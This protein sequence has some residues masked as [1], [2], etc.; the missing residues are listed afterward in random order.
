MASQEPQ[1]DDL[2][3]NETSRRRLHLREVRTDLAGYDGIGVEMRAAR[4]RAGTEL[5]DIAQKLRISQPYLEAIEEGR[6]DELPGHVYVFGFLKTYA[7][8]LELDEGI[9]IERFRAETSGPQRE[10]TRLAF[11]SAMDRG[12]LPTGRLLLGGLLVAVLAYAGW[13]VFTSDQRSTA[14]RVAEIP[15]RLAVPATNEV[16]AT[17]QPSPVATSEV[18]PNQG[19]DAVVEAPPPTVVERAPVGQDA[20]IPTDSTPGQ[21]AVLVP[22]EAPV[23]SA[24]IPPIAD[25]A[26]SADVVT[27]PSQVVEAA[28]TTADAESSVVVETPSQEA[29]QP[30]SVESPATPVVAQTP[31]AGTSGAIPEPAS[32]TNAPVDPQ[33]TPEPPAPSVVVSNPVEIRQLADA[34]TAPIDAENQ[35]SRA[36]LLEAGGAGELAPSTDEPVEVATRSDQSAPPPLATTAENTDAAATGEYVPRVFGAGNEGARVVLVADAESWVQV[37]TTSGELLLTRV[38]KQGDRY[39]VP[40]RSDLV[41]MTGNVGA[42]QVLVDGDAI[43]KLGPMGVIGRNIPLDADRLQVGQVTVDFDA[44]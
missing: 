24:T 13:F 20:A 31:T 14:D 30:A 4:I 28:Q 26:E 5:P 12:R 16:D 21:A 9:V 23:V 1:R 19:T 10:A 25:A 37:R 11:P 38:L 41:L 42:L 36:A 3:P 39:L 29:A 15:E 32:A 44:E 27:P 35:A 7:R 6:F 33:I 2:T 22:D 17:P 34:S 18:E 8:F 40:N 43:P